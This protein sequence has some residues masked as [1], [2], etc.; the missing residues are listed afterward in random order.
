MLSKLC[1]LAD[2]LA[3]GISRSSIQPGRRSFL[4]TMLEAS[5]A[6][7]AFLGFAQLS[8][9]QGAGCM[10]NL[11]PCTASEYYAQI[12]GRRSSSR[13]LLFVVAARGELLAMLVVMW[14]SGC[15]N[16]NSCVRVHAVV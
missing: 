16:G 12:C 10:V 11:A 2:Q 13:R 15:A 4:R 14:G 5:G 9:A 7:A 1:D 3:A 8:R 6:V